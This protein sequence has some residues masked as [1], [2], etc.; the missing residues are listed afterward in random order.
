MAQITTGLIENTEVSGVRP[1]ST[2]SVRISNADSTSA[3]IRINGFYWNGITMTEFV[4]DLLTLAPGEVADCNFYAKLDAFEFRFVT[5]SDTVEISAWGGNADGDLT[6]VHSLQPTELFPMGM[7][8]IAGTPGM[9][10]PSA[11]N[12]IYVLNYSGNNIS[13]IDG[14]TNTFIGNVIVGSGPFGVGVNPI[15]NRIYV[16]NFGSNN[17]SVIDGISNTVITTVTVGT[18]PVGV[19]VNPQTNRIYVT[20]WG[21]HNVS[22]ID[23]FT[24]VVIATIPVGVSP[25]GV[26]VNPSTNRIYIT[27]HGSNNV[28]VIDGNINSVIATVDVGRGILP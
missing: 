14:K 9:V 2:L 16:A 6:V 7:E 18:N 3:N 15:T 1:S 20:N 28:T 17:V 5:S 27:N 8:G 10:I 23:G 26:N 24:H 25:E 22:V 4:F 21:R 19:G 11:L 13:V 12:R